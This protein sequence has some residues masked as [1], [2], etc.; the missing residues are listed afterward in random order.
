MEDPRCNRAAVRMEDP[1]CQNLL[2]NW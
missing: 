1:R 2:M